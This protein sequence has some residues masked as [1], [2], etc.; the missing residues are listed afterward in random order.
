MRLWLQFVLLV[1]FGLSNAYAYQGTSESKYTII[2]GKLNPKAYVFC[3]RFND[4]LTGFINHHIGCD[5]AGN[6]R[7]ELQI[8]KPYVYMI[9][10][11]AVY[12]EPGDSLYFTLDA[13]GAEVFSGNNTPQQNFFNE[14][15][16]TFGAITLLQGRGKDYPDVMKYKKWI[17][18]LLD[19]EYDFLRQ[20]E[21][22]DKLSSGFKAFAKDN[23]TYRYLASFYAVFFEDSSLYNKPEYVSKVPITKETFN[24][25]DLLDSRIYTFALHYYNRY[26]VGSYI[27]S[28]KRAR[29]INEYRN[30]ATT[31]SGKSRE[32]LLFNILMLNYKTRFDVFDSLINKY[33]S[34]YHGSLYGYQLDSV[35]R[36]YRRDIDLGGNKALLASTLLDPSGA[37]IT[38]GKLLNSNKDKV[39]YLDF[40]ASW[41]VPCLAEMPAS[42][43]LAEDRELKNVSFVYLSID[44]AKKDWKTA[45]QKRQLNT[46]LHYIID[47]EET[48]NLKEFFKVNTI[49][50]YIII[51]QANNVLMGDAPRPSSPNIRKALLNK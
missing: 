2:T 20:Y 34:E 6:F 31:F 8:K 23:M 3:Y 14:F 35:Y 16:K 38:F 25:A 43:K 15:Q 10:Q 28:E 4:Y 49:P 29:L 7:L 11:R 42:K 39:L 27:A 45:I 30:A 5:S 47:K 32:Y 17:D 26:L 44:L 21:E 51:D 40:W 37:K 48:E 1:L 22:K 13:S 41:C 36:A 33:R 46:G 50:R 18:D 12:I 19:R 24:R 9:Q